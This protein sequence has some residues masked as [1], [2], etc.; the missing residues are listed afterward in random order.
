M[1]RTFTLHDK[2]D[3]SGTKRCLTLAECGAILLTKSGRRWTIEYDKTA[4]RQKLHTDGIVRRSYV[5]F[6]IPQHGSKTRLAA[7]EARDYHDATQQLLE[8]AAKFTYTGT[9]ADRYAVSERGKP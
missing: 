2:L 6:V 5:L 4:P 8:R 7:C 1:S 3:V 9:P